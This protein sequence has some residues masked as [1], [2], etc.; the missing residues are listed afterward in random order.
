MP[1]SVIVMVV[2]TAVQSIQLKPELLIECTLRACIRK[3][4][5]QFFWTR[6]FVTSL[7]ILITLEFAAAYVRCFA[8]V[9]MHVIEIRQSR[10][11]RDWL[12]VSM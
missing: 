11:F 1:I 8:E 12:H 5:V 4:G 7:R 3:Y 10:A 6:S 9:V 2:D